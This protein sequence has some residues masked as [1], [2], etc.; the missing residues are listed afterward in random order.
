MH[1][2]VK[3][4]LVETVRIYRGDEKSLHE[5]TRS[6][7][8]QL[9]R[10]HPK[11]NTS[12]SLV[13]TSGNA[14]R[15]ILPSGSYAGSRGMDVLAEAAWHHDRLQDGLDPQVS[16]LDI[17][18]TTGVEEAQGDGLQ[19]STVHTSTTQATNS[20]NHE[21]YGQHLLCQWPQDVTTYLQSEEDLQN[22]FWPEIGANGSDGSAPRNCPMRNQAPIHP[23]HQLGQAGMTINASEASYI[24]PVWA[25]MSEEQWL[26]V[27][28]N[29]SR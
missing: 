9:Y 18:P 24:G 29:F 19:D 28:A 27:F 2:T 22:R 13:Q 23:N 15:S 17:D 20:M 16:R 6:T 14:M 26:D 5:S 8:A 10:A 4:L 1:N 11:Q 3:N 7:L 12:R 25:E 21:T